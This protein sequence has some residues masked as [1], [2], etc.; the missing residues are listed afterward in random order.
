MISRLMN[1]NIGD[2]VQK[3]VRGRDIDATELIKSE[4]GNDKICT[5]SSQITPR[6]KNFKCAWP[7]TRHISS[8][9]A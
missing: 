1:G 2:M 8:F 3:L 7:H 4:P 9:S 5:I 6:K